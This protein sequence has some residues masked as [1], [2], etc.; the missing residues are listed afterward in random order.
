MQKIMLQ[1]QREMR[2]ADSMLQVVR[3]AAAM[4][5]IAMCYEPTA[6]YKLSYNWWPSIRRAAA[7]HGGILGSTT[8]V[9]V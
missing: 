4:Q 8:F 5:C 3:R 1:I 6:C 9:S 7:L 2:E